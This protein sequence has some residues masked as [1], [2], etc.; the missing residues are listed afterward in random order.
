MHASYA[1]TFRSAGKLHPVRTIATAE[2]IIRCFTGLT[3]IL[4]PSAD[5]ARFPLIVSALFNLTCRRKSPES[6]NVAV[7]GDDA[8]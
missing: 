6:V 8:H 1:R 2:A 5:G 3:V 7:A 4:P